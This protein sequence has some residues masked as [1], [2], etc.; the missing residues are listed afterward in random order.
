M[1]KE[2]DVILWIYL[3]CAS[4][5]VLLKSEREDTL[6]GHYRCGSTGMF[7]VRESQAPLG[8]RGNYGK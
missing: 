6:A 3:Y 1:A 8:L 5:M 7:R 4:Q 2:A